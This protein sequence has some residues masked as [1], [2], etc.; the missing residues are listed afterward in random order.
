LYLL[1][2]YFCFSAIRAA[3]RRAAADPE[4][5]ALTEMAFSLRLSLMAFVVTAIFASNAYYFYFPMLAGLCA[6]LER[7]LHRE[8]T[9]F[10]PSPPAGL[11]PP[12]PATR[13]AL[14][15]VQR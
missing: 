9:V 5:R 3:R 13:R 11:W 2:V 4:M 1:A 15:A 14:P 8:Q 12:P 7:I 6:A 10:K